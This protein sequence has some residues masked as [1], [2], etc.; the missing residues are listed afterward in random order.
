MESNAASPYQPWQPKAF[1]DDDPGA[2]RPAPEETPARE[3]VAITDTASGARTPGAGDFE[4]GVRAGPA[5]ETDFAAIKFQRETTLLTNADE[6]AASI[7]REAQL[8]VKQIRGEVDALNA[9]AEQRYAE[10]Q[11]VKEQAEADAAQRVAEA[12]NQADAVREEA[13]REGFEAGEVEGMR[14]RYEEAGADLKNLEAICVEMARFRRHVTFYVEKDSIR[15]AV[16]LAKKIL[17]QELKVNKQVVLQLLAKTISELEGSG[18]FRVWLS[19]DDHKFALA[20]RPTLEK[21]LGED[22]ALSLR[23]RPSLAPGSVLIETDREMI[24]LTLASQ[25]HHLDNLLTQTL[26]ERETVV[27]K[28]RDG[29]AQSP[30]APKP[31]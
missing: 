9:A 6:Y 28:R 24:D 23:A 3:F 14:K 26:S 5:A 25:F 2:P 10:A 18:T 19:P 17:R 30:A 20:A 31:A 12:Q 21:F 16:L 13:R 29:P 27:T 1:E 22:Q 15:L 7:R 4:D 8:Y 11:Q